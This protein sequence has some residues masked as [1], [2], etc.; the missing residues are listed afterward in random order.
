MTP[1]LQFQADLLGAGRATESAGDDRPARPTRR[2]AG[3]WT[4][5]EEIAK[6]WKVEQRF[7]PRMKRDEAE[8]R[9]AEWQRALERAKG[10]QNR[11]VIP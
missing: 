1:A 10:W 8:R 7:Q 4:S 11:E 2:P 5:R 9:M 6:Q 3:V